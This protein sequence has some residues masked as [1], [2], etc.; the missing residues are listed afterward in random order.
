MVETLR[1]SRKPTAAANTLVLTIEV[2]LRRNLTLHPQLLHLH[3]R[4]LLLLASLWNVDIL[5][6]KIDKGYVSLRPD[7]AI[8]S[9]NSSR[10]SSSR[11]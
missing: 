5:I 4:D 3:R 6:S 8:M 2:A 1:G 11:P 7:P 10:G 9:I